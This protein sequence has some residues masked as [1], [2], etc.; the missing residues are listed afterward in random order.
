MFKQSTLL[1]LYYTFIYPYFIYCIEIWGNASDIYLSQIIKL[2]KRAIRMIV[3]ENY[4][5]HTQPIYKQLKILPL[6]QVFEYFVILF[7]FKNVN[8]L[9]SNV[10]KCMFKKNLDVCSCQTR[11]MTKL[12]KPKAKTTVLQKSISHIGINKNNWY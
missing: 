8:N 10:F 5:A 11:Q 3:S 2:Q 4:K 1:T 7:M 9:V 6:K 12:Y